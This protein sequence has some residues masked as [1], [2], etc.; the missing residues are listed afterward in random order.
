MKNL[1]PNLHGKVFHVHVS[2]YHI[3]SRKGYR[4]IYV[5]EH[6]SKI[7]LPVFLSSVLKSQF[8]YEKVPWQE[9]AEKT[10]KDLCEGNLSAFTELKLI[11]K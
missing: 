7:I 11:S 8:D 5:V 6:K 1:P 4:L 9:F 10:Y 2:G 3:P